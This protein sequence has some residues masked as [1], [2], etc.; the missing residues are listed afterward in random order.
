MADIR[1]SRPLIPGHFLR[2]LNRFLALVEWRG[3]ES[4][5]TFGTRDAFV[6]S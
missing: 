1:F 6:N 3:G 2:R 4:A 5:S